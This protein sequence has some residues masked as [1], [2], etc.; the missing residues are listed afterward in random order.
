[1]C[2][3]IAPSALYTTHP[4]IKS[5]SMAEIDETEVS[6]SESIGREANVHVEL[7][8]SDDVEITVDETTE[9]EVEVMSDK[10]DEMDGILTLT[11]SEDDIRFSSGGE[12]SISHVKQLVARFECEN[13]DQTERIIRQ[14]I[15]H[16][17]SLV[18]TII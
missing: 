12:V 6:M 4:C 11:E 13:S 1:M 18:N 7:V 9:R 5:S 2:H 8:G 15:I 16:R 17:L 3:I 10:L 14:Q